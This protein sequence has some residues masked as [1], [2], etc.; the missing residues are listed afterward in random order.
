MTVLP[1]IIIRA[2][3]GFLLLAVGTDD[4][5]IIVSILDQVPKDIPPAERVARALAHA[6]PAILITT[7]TSAIAFFAGST[8]RFPAMRAF[9][10]DAAI[11]IVCV[12]LTACTAII[13]C[14][15][16][17]EHRSSPFDRWVDQKRGTDKVAAD[18]E[19]KEN[20]DTAGWRGFWLQT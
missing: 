6:G 18:S 5:F 13:A 19:T 11:G 7:S 8:I 3:C 4:V 15:S 12:F 14:I 17:H 16:I 9:C 20:A 2:V 10:L 1:T